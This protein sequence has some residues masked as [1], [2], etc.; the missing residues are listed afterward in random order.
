MELMR[1][2]LV[3]KLLIRNIQFIMGTPERIVLA[4]LGLMWLEWAI[5][6]TGGSVC[7][8]PFMV[9]IIYHYVYY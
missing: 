6:I 1:L 8:V 2:F 7:R 9:G 3:L 4:N 5:S